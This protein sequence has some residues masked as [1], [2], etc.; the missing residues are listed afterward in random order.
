MRLPDRASRIAF[1]FFDITLRDGAPIQGTA[2][3]VAT[4]VAGVTVVQLSTVGL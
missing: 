1:P 2:T 4:V 3:A